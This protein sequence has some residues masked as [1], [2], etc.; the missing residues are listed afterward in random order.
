MS[1]RLRRLAA[2][3]GLAAAP[4]RVEGSRRLD[5]AQRA[6]LLEDIQEDLGA[7]VDDAENRGITEGT[8]AE[9]Q[10][11]RALVD[12]LEGGEPPGDGAIGYLERV[13]PRNPGAGEL[14]RRD[15]YLA[16]IGELGG[17]EEA[18][19]ELRPEDVDE[20]MRP[21]LDLQGRKLRGRMEELGLTTGE[22][23]RR[24]GIDAV[25]LVALLSGQEELRARQSTDLSEALEV[26]LEWMF[27][28]VRFVPGTGP[29][30]RGF[31]EIAPERSGPAGPGDAAD[32]LGGDPPDDSGPVIGGGD[33]DR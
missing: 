16:A 29:E 12:W 32:G 28:G 30:R 13:V 17:D 11:V 4:R 8:A 2:R 14:A 23:A 3:I 20:Q 10:V 18:A 31:Y 9:M 7:M 26:P 6:W 15:T 1:G 19:G 22:L 27:E 24:S 33:E 25:T 21:L 5:T